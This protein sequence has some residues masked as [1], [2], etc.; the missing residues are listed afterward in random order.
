MSY[1]GEARRSAFSTVGAT[2]GGWL[3]NGVLGAVRLVKAIGHRRYLVQLGEFDDHMLKDI[4]LTRADLRDASSGP[5]WQDPTATLVVRSVERRA[6]RR[7]VSRA[8]LRLVSA[9]A[10]KDDL[11]SCG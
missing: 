8:N 11:I 1:F 7:Q 5:L 6:S 2:A 10:P 3:V 4:G 9:P